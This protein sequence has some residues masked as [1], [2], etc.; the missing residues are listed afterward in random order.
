MCL[1]GGTGFEGIVWLNLIHSEAP[2][3][4][5]VGHLMAKAND[6]ALFVVC[7]NRSRA[8]G[9]SNKIILLLFE[10]DWSS[11]IISFSCFPQTH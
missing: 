2:H 10:S 11:D 8:A 4:R 6:V 1:Y 9:Y 3:T 7:P 5:T